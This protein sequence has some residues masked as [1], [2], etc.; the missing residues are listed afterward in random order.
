MTPFI[1]SLDIVHLRTR[2]DKEYSTKVLF[3]GH[4]QLF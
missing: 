4:N 2:A 3:P 1:V